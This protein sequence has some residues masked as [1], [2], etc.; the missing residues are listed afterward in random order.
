METG[1]DTLRIPVK[2]QPLRRPELDP[3]IYP[4]PISILNDVHVLNAKRVT[5]PQN[6]TGIVGLVDIFENDCRKPRSLVEDVL[7]AGSTI[8]GDKLFEDFDVAID[9]VVTLPRRWI[10]RQDNLLTEL[11][12]RRTNV[13]M[14]REIHSLAIERLDSRGR[15][16]ATHDERTVRVVGGVPGDVVDVRVKRRKAGE[17]HAE[18]ISFSRFGR[19]R[20]TAFCEH[21]GTCGG[22]TIQDLAYSDQL[23]LKE[24]IVRA[25]FLENGY[26]IDTVE[27]LSRSILA[28]PSETRFR[29]KMEYSFGAQRWLSAEELARDDVIEDRRG[30]GL[31]VPGRFDRVLDLNECFLQPDPSEDIRRFVG[32][33]SRRRGL[34]YYDSHE[35]HG[36]LRLLIVRTSLAGETMVTIMFGEDRPTERTELFSA[37]RAA[38]PGITSLNYV[39]NST[40]NDSI[41]A[42]DIIHVDGPER[43]HERCGDLTLSLGPKTFYQTNPEQ[44]FRLYSRAF[45][46]LEPLEGE[47][48]FDLYSG[49]GSIAL[50]ASRHV[51]R[52]VGIES[53]SDSVVS[54][55]RNAQANA[56][57]NCVFELGAVEAVLEAVVDRHGS[58]DLVVLDPPRSGIH[59]RARRTLRELGAPRILYISCNPRTQA[60]DCAD[61]ADAYEITAMQAVDMFP[62]TRHVENICVLRRLDSADSSQ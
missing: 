49:V 1:L 31:H 18:P 54:A 2:G 34:S 17:L 8:F 38:I 9:H 46:L 7:H 11:K 62:Q 56:I 58:P 47:L 44:A 27:E 33:Y 3:G 12:T 52:V 59:P 28:A 21:F 55:R 4:I 15:G 32:D 16:V 43:V 41:Y 19:D 10:V 24:A 60:S 30:L 5:G 42:H 50:F 61:L 51:S 40:K 6:G 26:S 45:E 13:A 23:A 25:A 35:H 14:K 37:L 57:K 39:I 48:L 29:N 53:V 22:C 36:F 20:R